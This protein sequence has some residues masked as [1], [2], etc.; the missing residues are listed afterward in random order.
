M[1]KKAVAVTAI[2][3][4]L[5]ILIWD[6]FLYADNVPGNSIT[7]VVIA[8]SKEYPLIPYFIGFLMGFL[9]AHFFDTSSQGDKKQ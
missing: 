5:S 2:A 4:F 1:T 8:S 6:A 7:Q 3:I 9:A